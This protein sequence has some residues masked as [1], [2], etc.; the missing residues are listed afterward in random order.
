MQVHGP[1]NVERAL[2]TDPTVLHCAS[3]IMEQKEC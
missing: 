1:N 2:R 3:T